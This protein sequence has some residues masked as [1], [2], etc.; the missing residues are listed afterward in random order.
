MWQLF[1]ASF[2]DQTEIE[3]NGR[4]DNNN[5]TWQRLRSFKQDCLS[6]KIHFIIWWYLVCIIEALI[7]F[8]LSHFKFLRQKSRNNFARFLEE[9]R[10]RKFASEIYR[11]LL[12][13][14]L[15]ISYLSLIRG[16][17][18]SCSQFISLSEFWAAQGCLHSSTTTESA[19]AGIKPK[20]KTFLRPQE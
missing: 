15:K 10:T 14:R 18:W 19:L 17:H 1:I 12:K 20:I 6:L 3:G 16:F 5:K 7:F 4:Q 2:C 9:R 11:Y 8:Y 13:R